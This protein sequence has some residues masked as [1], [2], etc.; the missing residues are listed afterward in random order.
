[1]IFINDEFLIKNRI[2]L[3]TFIEELQGQKFDDLSDQVI[4]C[5]ISYLLDVWDNIEKSDL[6]IKK[7]ISENLSPVAI[8]NITEVSDYTKIE[9]RAISSDKDFEP[10][11]SDVKAFEQLCGKYFNSMKSLYDRF[12]EIN[13]E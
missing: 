7:Y 12:A 11:E 9:V 3:N 13:I 10:Q 4:D 2:D 5:I 6:M 1:M 8:V